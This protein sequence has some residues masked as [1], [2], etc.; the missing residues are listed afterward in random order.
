MSGTTTSP[1]TALEAVNVR[2]ICQAMG[3]KQLGD[4]EWAYMDE[5]DTCG[6]CGK[7]QTRYYNVLLGA[8]QCGPCKGAGR[9]E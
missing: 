8:P 2:A 3:F 7:N 5:P 6:V 9:R 1:M 4:T